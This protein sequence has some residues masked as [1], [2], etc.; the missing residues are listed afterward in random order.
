M[1]AEINQEGA[2]GGLCSSCLGD[3]FK[4]KPPSLHLWVVAFLWAAKLTAH[5]SLRKQG[6]YLRASEMAWGAGRAHRP[7]SHSLSLSLSLTQSAA[8]SLSAIM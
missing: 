4:Q 5:W 8:L 3:I 7:A 1:L 2:G 6:I